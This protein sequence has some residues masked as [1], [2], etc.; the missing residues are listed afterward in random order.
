MDYKSDINV[1]LLVTLAIGGGLLLIV[2]IIGVQ[3]WISYVEQTAHGDEAKT[4]VVGSVVELRAQQ[5]KNIGQIEQ[6]MRRYVALGGRMP[7]T[8]ATTRAMSGSNE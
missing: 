5:S 1:P 3:A 4:A 6:A 8:R 7:Q 2:I